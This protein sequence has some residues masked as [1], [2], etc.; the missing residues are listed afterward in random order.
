MYLTGNL[1]FLLVLR[2]YNSKFTYSQAR[3]GVNEKHRYMINPN[4]K[5]EKQQFTVSGPSTMAKI[6][7]NGF[8][9]DLVNMS[10]SGQVW[11]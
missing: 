8:S 2:D 1:T 4:E 6:Y 7:I 11:Q 10:D 9:S 5:T 3:H